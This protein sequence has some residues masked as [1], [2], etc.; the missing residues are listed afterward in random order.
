M[1]TLTERNEVGDDEH[2]STLLPGVR[3]SEA[4]RRWLEGVEGTGGCRW[5]RIAEPGA[6][7]APGVLGAPG[8]R[9]SPGVRGGRPMLGV[10]SAPG[11]EGGS[12][13]LRPGCGSGVIGRDMVASAGGCWCGVGESESEKKRCSV[14]VLYALVG[15]EVEVKG[16]FG[17]GVYI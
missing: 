5:T 15:P 17:L 7:G 2:G 12:M 9:G 1:C 6:P 10:M 3:G 13:S 16:E 14:G 11:V 4:M 8:V